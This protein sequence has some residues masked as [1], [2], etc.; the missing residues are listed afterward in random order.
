[1]PHAI[2]SL[3]QPLA[4]GII[5]FKANA[6]RKAR[7]IT[8]GPPVSGPERFDVEGWGGDEESFH[9]I[10]RR[11][12]TY[13]RCVILSGDVHFSSGITL[14]FWSGQD[15]TG[16][17]A[18]RAADVVAGAQQRG[19]GDPR[20]HLLRPLLP[21]AAARPAPRTARLGRDVLDHRPPGAGDLAG[22]PQPD[23]GDP[24]VVPA[25]G[26]AVGH[27]DPGRQAA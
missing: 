25:G 6:K 1:M 4:A 18:D 12:A 14:D 26:M 13:P 27:D 3:V 23:E 10:V 21:A 9:A 20:R 7:P 17:L 22:A 24:A 16:R 2:E 8:T 11:L 19:G 15:P 5:D